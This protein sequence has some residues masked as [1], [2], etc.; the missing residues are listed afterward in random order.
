MT[1]CPLGQDQSGSA[2]TQTEC[3][4][5][6]YANVITELSGKHRHLIPPPLWEHTQ[7]TIHLSCSSRVIPSAYLVRNI[8]NQW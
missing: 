6:E 1:N 2:I 4:M 3:M 7:C 8:P 5:T